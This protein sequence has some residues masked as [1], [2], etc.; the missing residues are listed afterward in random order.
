MSASTANSW[1]RIPSWLSRLGL[2]SLLAA[3]VLG[4]TTGGMSLAAQHMADPAALRERYPVTLHVF[5]MIAV[6]GLSVA[7]A[8]ALARRG[9]PL[10]AGLVLVG[11]AVGPMT[12]VAVPVRAS[13]VDE[14]TL[15]DTRMWWHVV[16]AALLTAVL[17]GWTW[18]ADRCLNERTTERPAASDGS[19]LAA[20][21]LFAVVAAAG[22]SAYFLIPPQS[23]EPVMRAVVGW[24][25]LAAGI[26]VAAGFART[27]WASLDFL[28]GVAATAG[29]I[30]LAYTRLGGWPGVA[31][32]E[33]DGMESPIITSVA[34][35]VMMFAAPFIG[36]ATWLARRGIRHPGVAGRGHGAEGLTV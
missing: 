33:Y 28:V 8:A 13:L 31:G 29:L 7:V 25:L 24:A 34:S 14:S 35:T 2:G 21:A 18:W 5:A 1:Q 20:A 27:L 10:V 19:R 30:F 3:A 26:A 4:V 11:S 6:A 23:N 9:L 32:W 36:S 12:V 17:V 15:G 16:V 22:L